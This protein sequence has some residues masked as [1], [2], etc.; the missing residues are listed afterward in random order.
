MVTNKVTLFEQYLQ[1]ILQIPALKESCALKKFLGI[2]LYC[3][4]FFSEALDPSAAN[5]RT[6]KETFLQQEGKSQLFGSL[7]EF[8]MD[9]HREEPPKKNKDLL[10][11]I[12]ALP[13]SMKKKPTAL[14][15]EIMKS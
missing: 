4:E 13:E 9:S 7:N 11:F 8:I 1:D 15:P 6:T 2:D 14:Q 10:K 5:G 3:P 12:T